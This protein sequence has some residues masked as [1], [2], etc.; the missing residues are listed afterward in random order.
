M[1]DFQLFD[2]SA[3]TMDFD[4]VSSVNPTLKRLPSF[5][6]SVKFNFENSTDISKV[7]FQKLGSKIPEM[8]N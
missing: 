1:G 6:T 5:P 3:A 2:T 4:T 8:V 7:L